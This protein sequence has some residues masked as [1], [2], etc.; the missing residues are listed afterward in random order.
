[1]YIE[2]F[3]ELFP[4]SIKETEK[5]RAGFCLRFSVSHNKWLVGYGLGRLKKYERNKDQIGSG[6]TIREALENMV[7]KIKDY[8]FSNKYEHTTRV[9]KASQK[10]ARKRVL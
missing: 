1:M 2:E 8:N 7:G 3:L 5:D 9:D 4:T 6:D 10:I